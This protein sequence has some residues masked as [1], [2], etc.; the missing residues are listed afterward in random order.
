MRTS[1]K[2]IEF[3]LPPQ[4]KKK[5]CK[6]SA[7]IIVHVERM[8]TPKQKSSDVVTVSPKKRKSAE[9]VNRNRGKKTRNP[10]RSK[11]STEA[12]K[13]AKTSTKL[14]SLSKSAVKP[15]TPAE[16]YAN[17]SKRVK[18]AVEYGTAAAGA[19]VKGTNQ[20][21]AKAKQPSKTPK[22]RHQKQND[23]SE[24]KQQQ[25]QHKPLQ[26]EEQEREERGQQQARRRG[27]EVGQHRKMIVR[28]ANSAQ[29]EY[30]LRPLIKK[31][32]CH[33]DDDDDD[34]CHAPR[35]AKKQRQCTPSVNFAEKVDVTVFEV[36]PR[37][38]LRTERRQTKHLQLSFQPSRGVTSHAKQSYTFV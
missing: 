19:A 22:T 31:P 14:Q 8:R 38:P 28:P 21:A 10:T 24:S 16:T 12:C 17:H 3:S 18:K 13:P 35:H 34:D 6:K 29:Y 9:R 5:N 33:L 11:R 37:Y 23:K 15:S 27:C 32:R 36:E 4:H 25:R 20:A 2:L 30:S 26:R 7:G 1:R